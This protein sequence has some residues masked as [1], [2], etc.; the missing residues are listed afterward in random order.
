MRYILFFFID[1]AELPKKTLRK[2]FECDIYKTFS[3]KLRK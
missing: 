3:L 2:S 1:A